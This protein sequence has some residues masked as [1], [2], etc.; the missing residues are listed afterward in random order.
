M[1]LERKDIRAK[2]DPDYHA[3]LL[4]LCEADHVDLGEFVERELRRVIEQRVHA[5]SL[6]AARTARLGITGNGRELQGIAVIGHGL[7]P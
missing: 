5:A 1:S 3:A 7:Q 2:I 6:I 4:V